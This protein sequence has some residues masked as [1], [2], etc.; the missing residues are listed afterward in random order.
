MKNSSNKNSQ[1]IRN[2]VSNNHRKRNKKILKNKSNKMVMHLPNKNSHKL[3]TNPV[4][5]YNVFMKTLII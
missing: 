4:L 5:S 1:K 3:I 2:K